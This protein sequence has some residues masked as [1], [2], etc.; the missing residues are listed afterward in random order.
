ML[1][2]APELKAHHQMQFSVIRRSPDILFLTEAILSDNK[3]FCWR[4]LSRADRAGV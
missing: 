2:R 3:R 4:S 1:L